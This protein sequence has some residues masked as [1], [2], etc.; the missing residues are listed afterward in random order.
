MSAKQTEYRWRTADIKPNEQLKWELE[1]PDISQ[2]SKS[3]T[4]LFELFYDDAVID[5]LCSESKKYASSKGKHDFDVCP[6]EMNVFLGIFLVSGYSGCKRRR[7]YW[8]G[9]GDVRHEAIANAMARD[10][11]DEIM[12]YFHIADNSMLGQADKFY[13]VRPL[14]SMLNSRFHKHFLGGRDLSVDES[15]VPYFGKHG[16]KQF[17]RGK[18][19]RHGYKMWV[20]ATPIGYVVNMV[21]YQGATGE[22]ESQASV[23]VERLSW[24]LC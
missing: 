8:S 3:V 20:L 2:L 16:A 24:A 13:K 5:L 10:S 11:F 22:K 9:E 19:I 12:R 1:Q 23:W 17:I 21:P 18:P 15:M 14:M 7:L 4:K 6:D